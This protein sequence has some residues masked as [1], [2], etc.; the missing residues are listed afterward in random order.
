MIDS[1]CVVRC[2]APL[3]TGCKTEDY[4]TRTD[5]LLLRPGGP[6]ESYA[7]TY[8]IDYWSFPFEGHG[9]PQW[10]SYWKK[11][12]PKLRKYSHGLAAAFMAVEHLKPDALW[13]IGYDRLMGRYETGKSWES[14]LDTW[15]YSMSAHDWEAEHN[16]LLGLGVPIHE[17][18]RSSTN[19]IL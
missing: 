12:S 8:G 6:H 2:K 16:A 19:T 18:C 11:Y 9:F 14:K 3:P 4:G 15:K 13:V 17:L 10:V 1:F 5:H 7:R